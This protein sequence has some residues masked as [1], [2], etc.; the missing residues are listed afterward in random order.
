V[1][2]DFEEA[3]RHAKMIEQGRKTSAV[4]KKNKRA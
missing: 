4:S 3:V 2:R 1:E